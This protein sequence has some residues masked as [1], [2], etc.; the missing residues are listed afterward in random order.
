MLSRK[1]K[2][3]NEDP[4]RLRVQSS[5]EIQSLLKDLV[6]AKHDHDINLTVQIFVDHVNQVN[7][8]GSGSTQVMNKIKILFLSANPQGTNPLK[9]DEEAREIQLKIRAAEYRDSMEFITQW[10]ARPDDLLQFLN[11]YKPDIVHFSGHGSET[12]EIIL[13]D[14]NGTP[15]PVSKAALVSLFRNFKKSTRVAVLNACFSQPQAE[16]IAEEIGCAIGM[17]REI[18]DDAAI[19]FAGSFYRAIGFGC[20]VQEA[21]EQGK[22]A[23]LG[24]DIPEEKTP[25][26]MCRNGMKAD[27]I[28]LIKPSAGPTLQ[29]EIGATGLKDEYFGK[30]KKCNLL[31]ELLRMAIREIEDVTRTDYNQIFL[32]IT[33][34][35]SN[36][37][38]SVADIVPSHKQRYKKALY[39]GLLGIAMSSGKTL[40]IP[41]V[42]QERRY[43]RAVPETKSEL[44]VPIRG[45]HSIIGVINSES[46]EIAGFGGDICEKI[47]AIASALGE[48][49][50]VY[51]WDATSPPPRLPLIELS[52][53]KKK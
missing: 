48:L 7:V 11:Q 3:A 27:A 33:D 4:L 14:K 1:L 50:P 6:Q 52:P 19:V 37:L 46:E 42:Q 35:H 10:A 12:E 53:R 15:K 5:T 9:L 20:S 13:L 29:P 21:F 2:F 8:L 25:A 24:E 47:E 30:F 41:N 28:I 44:A 38:I 34:R 17:T 49:L 51:G 22:T 26:L 18:T 23:L 36:Y 39:Q 40:N 45:E 31:G 16:S 43:Y 32:S